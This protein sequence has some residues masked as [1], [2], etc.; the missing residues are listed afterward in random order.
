VIPN[1]CSIFFHA[2]YIQTKAVTMSVW[3]DQSKIVTALIQT[4]VITIASPIHTKD[5]IIAREGLV[6]KSAMA[7]DNQQH[8]SVF[9]P[10]AIYYFIF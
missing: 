6:F 9:S 10:T 2:C 8:C 3:H 1:F 4:T 5:I 7:R